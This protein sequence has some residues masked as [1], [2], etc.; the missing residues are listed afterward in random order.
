MEDPTASLLYE[1]LMHMMCI[2]FLQ[3]QRISCPAASVHTDFPPCKHLWGLAAYTLSHACEGAKA[4]G[5]QQQF[6]S[7]LIFLI[8]FF[9]VSFCM[10]QSS[11]LPFML[12]LKAIFSVEKYMGVSDNY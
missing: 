9:S 10:L 1:Q 4:L 12:T 6:P 3:P 5:P 11:L 2:V 8:L 7:E